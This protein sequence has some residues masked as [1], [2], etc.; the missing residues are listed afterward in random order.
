MY[1]TCTCKIYTIAATLF[2][3]S[4]PGQESWLRMLGID[5]E[6]YFVA[7]YSCQLPHTRKVKIQR[8]KIKSS[9]NVLKRA[10]KFVCFLVSFI[11][12]PSR[13]LQAC[14]SEFSRSLRYSA[15][16]AV[17][18]WWIKFAPIYIPQPLKI[19]DS[20]SVT[21]QLVQSSLKFDKMC[22]RHLRV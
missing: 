14:E 17:S 18:V 11:P 21:L 6:I 3:R 8:E 9:P 16:L 13:F 10:I 12:P 19:I 2:A 1:N 7:N 4:R 22:L 15:G 20:K 5:F